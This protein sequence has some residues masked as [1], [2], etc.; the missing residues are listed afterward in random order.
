[1]VNDMSNNNPWIKFY[2]SVPATLS[3]PETTLY[4]SLVETVSKYP[5]QI[6]W[7]FL[8]TKYTYRKFLQE[9]D[10]FAKG[11]FYSV[12]IKQNDVVTISMP[13]SPQGIIPIYAINKLGAISAL[14][15]PLSPPDKIKYY[16]NVSN[17]KYAITLDNFYSNFDKILENTSVDKVIVSK[18]SDYLIRHKTLIFN[19]TKGRKIS[20]M[21]PSSKIIWYSDLMNQTYPE[22]VKDNINTNDC[23]VI[24][25][26]GGTTGDSKGIM[27]SN[28]NLISEGIQ[29]SCS[30][31]M[32]PTDKL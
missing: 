18:I 11:L 6:A 26:S 9:I 10:Q 29:A 20:K 4:G 5:D 13:T 1:M 2:G 12:G 25:Y 30:G 32:N 15:H 8:G 31:N 21:R 22:I 24:M 7:E 28:R 19:L 23:A 17:S 3:Y 27:L 16:L 14:I